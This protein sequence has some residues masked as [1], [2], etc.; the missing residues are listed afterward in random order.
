MA[1]GITA[2]IYK[3]DFAN[4]LKTSLHKSMANYTDNKIEKL[5]WDKLQKKV[6]AITYGKVTS[7]SNYLLFPVEVLRNR[8]AQ[9][10][11]HPSCNVA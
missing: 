2:A 6:R 1:A 9:R 10:L 8:Q 4:A 5:A 3:A 11:E 7:G